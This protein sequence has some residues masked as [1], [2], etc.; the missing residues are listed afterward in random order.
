MTRARLTR[1]TVILGAILALTFAHNLGTSTAVSFPVTGGLNDPDLSSEDR[2]LEAYI[3]DLRKF[4][5]KVAELGEKGSLTRSEFDPLQRTSDDLKRRLSVVQNAIRGAITKLKGTGNW[6]NLDTTLKARITDPKLQ[7]FHQTSFKERLEK[8]ASELNNQASEISDPIEPLRKKIAV[9]DLV[10]PAF[11][12][13]SSPLALRVIPV[14][15]EPDPV[16]TKTTSLGCRLANIRL[17]ISGFI[18]KDGPTVAAQQ[19][20]TCACYDND[21][22]CSS[23]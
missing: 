20:Q 1:M 6:N 17:G 9:A 7:A 15:Y 18:H 14:A 19:A 10:S 16:L 2:T 8:A 3:Q 5:K 22:D 21:P 23:Q 4:Q 13:A 11:E 12:N